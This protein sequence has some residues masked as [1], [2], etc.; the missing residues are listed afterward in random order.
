MGSPRVWCGCSFGEKAEFAPEV[1]SGRRAL[2]RDAGEALEFLQF[3]GDRFGRL[4]AELRHDAVDAQICERAQHVVADAKR[5]RDDDLEP[6]A[7]TAFC[8][9]RF[10]QPLQF[11]RRLFR[12]DG[13]AVPTRAVARGAP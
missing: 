2:R 9:E 11:L 10:V 12:A 8:G 13:E 3:C 7:G 5:R 6:F 1:P 4:C